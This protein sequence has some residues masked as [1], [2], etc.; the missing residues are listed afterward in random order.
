LF[1][2]IRSAKAHTGTYLERKKLKQRENNMANGCKLEYEEKEPKESILENTPL[3]KLRLTEELQGHSLIKYI[4]K[5][6]TNKLIFGDNLHILKNLY[7]D[8]NICGHVNL[9][10]IDPQFSTKQEFKTRD[11]EQAYF[12]YLVGSEFVEFIR[13]RLVFMHELLS[14]NGSIYIHLDQ[15]MGH[16]IKII[17]DEVF[18]QDNFRNDITRIKCNPKNFKRKA[19]G[20][21]KDVIYFYS[22]V[23]V[24]GNHV[25]WNDYLPPS[26]N[27]ELEKRFKKIDKNGR[28]YATTPLHAKGETKNGVT[29]QP[30]KG[31]DPPKGRHWR[32]APEELTKLDEQGLIEWSK[33]RNPRKIIYADESL[34]KKVQDVWEFKDKG[35]NTSIYPT[36]K[37]EELL[38]FIINNSSRKGDLVLDCFSGSG[39]TLHAAEKFG[40]RWIGIDNS[41]TAIEISKKKLLG[42]E[43][44]Q[45]FSIYK[46]V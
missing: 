41:K 45:P 33:S 9:I 6:W 7:E 24:K 5:K 13:K 38:D 29:G 28:R 3:A 2:P 44:Y 46:Y 25:I 15:K 40:R 42:L 11:D 18:G 37:N 10:Y 32:Y 8:N 30:W 36:E 27:S 39:T 19:Y 1:A 21:T 34:G 12:D 22:K 14:D 35:I 20:N 23:N 43:N 31:M 16:Y 17:M 26:E 4:E